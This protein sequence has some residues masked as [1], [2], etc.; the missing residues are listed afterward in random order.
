M[1]QQFYKRQGKTLS[2]KDREMVAQI[3]GEISFTEG[4]EDQ[5][6]RKLGRLYGKIVGAK[7][8]NLQ[9]ACWNFV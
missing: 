8:R 5:L 6:V 1:L 2:D 4:D 3:V 9:I 7:R